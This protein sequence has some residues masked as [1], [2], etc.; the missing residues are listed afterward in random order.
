[1]SSSTRTMATAQAT[2]KIPSGPATPPDD[3]LAVDERPEAN[4]KPVFFKP[5]P[6]PEYVTGAKLYLIIFAMAFASFLSILDNM[7]VSTASLVSRTMASGSGLIV[8]FGPGHTEDHQRLSFSCRC[9]LVRQCLSV[10]EVRLAYPLPMRQLFACLTVSC[11]QV[12]HR[13][14]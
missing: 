11:P 12:L 6:N 3:G 9:R 2:N 13:S 1:M 7:I 5:K 8:Q 4:T 14:H 10:R